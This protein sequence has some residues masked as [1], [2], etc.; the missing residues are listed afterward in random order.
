MK[1]IFIFL[2]MTSLIFSGCKKN[3]FDPQPPEIEFG[4]FNYLEK[5]ANGRDS[6]VEMIIKFKD[7]NGDIGRSDE[8][9]K[10]S[11]CK[12][13]YPDLFMFYERYENGTYVPDILHPVTP[14]TVYDSNCNVIA[15]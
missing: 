4:G 13:S 14:D 15:I 7:V 3:K 2:C 11:Q 1:K 5:D 10:V 6:K 8:E 12:Y 9:T